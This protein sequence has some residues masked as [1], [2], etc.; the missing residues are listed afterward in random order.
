MYEDEKSLY[1]FMLGGVIC[2]IG[3]YSDQLK[4][5]L[6]NGKQTRE[7]HDRTG[8]PEPEKHLVNITRHKHHDRT[9]GSY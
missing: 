4:K 9:G 3:H 6:N 7:H 1:C 2:L 5:L 8:G